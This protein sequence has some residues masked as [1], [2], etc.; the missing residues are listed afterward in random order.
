VVRHTDTRADRD[1]VRREA[2]ECGAIRKQDREVIETEG[3][4]TGT[5]DAGPGMQL[6]EVRFV[7]VR[8]E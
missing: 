6:D 5:C 3:A 1:Q 2:A 7:A 4:A 8:A